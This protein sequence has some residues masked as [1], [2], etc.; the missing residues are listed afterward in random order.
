MYQDTTADRPEALSRRTFLTGAGLAVAGAAVAATMAETAHA[1]ETAPAEAEITERV[2]DGQ[3]LAIGRV[4]HDSDICSGCRTCEAVCTLYHEG[5]SGSELS[6]L[7]WDKD[8]MDACITDIYTCKQCAG[9]ECMAVCPT[10]ALHVDETT[11]ARVIDEK[12][13]TGCQLCMAACPCNPP[14]IKYNAA[15]NVCFK[16]DLCGGDPQCVKF[17]P[18]GALLSTWESYEVAEGEKSI[19]ETNITG[20]AKSWTHCELTSLVATE[21]A[22]GLAIEGVVWTSHATQFN[23]VLCNYTVTADVYDAA[24]N[25]IASSDAPG[26]GAIP[27][28]SSF[29]F[30]LNVGGASSLSKVGKIVINIDGGVVTNAPTEEA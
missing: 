8:T 16:C 6:R 23:V 15:K 25:V 27:E 1:A 28:M 30:A 19:F 3:Q 17:C 2:F 26:T 22:S 14:M 21:A 10:G 18:M 11:G 9:A 5:V 12:K 4:V 7:K 29:E 24:G 20:D 13:C